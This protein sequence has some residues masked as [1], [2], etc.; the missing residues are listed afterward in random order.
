M[1]L[2]FL[3]PDLARPD[4][5]FEPLAR[6][7]IEPSLRRAGA[8]FEVRDGWSVA[9]DLGD[10]AAEQEA[11]RS[12]V[13]VADRC[14]LGKLE[15]TGPA[16]S[17]PELAPG[18]A[19]HREGAWW[20][21][22]TAERMLVLCPPVA[23]AELRERLPAVDLTTGLAA[24]GIAGPRARDVLARLSALDLR[25]QSTP[26]GGFRPGSVARVP[27]MVLREGGDRFLVLFGSAYAQYVWTAVCD[28]AGPLGGRVV[29]AGQDA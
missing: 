8:R 16:S 15:V 20:C 24:V 21:P 1:S 14:A 13:A 12:S 26:E 11:A 25:P 9:I 29:G 5:G 2:D 3:S 10:A 19:V 22:V 6:S 4:R 7:P 18:A 27:A 23:T 17:L 28:A